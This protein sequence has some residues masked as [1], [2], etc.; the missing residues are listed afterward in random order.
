MRPR[1]LIRCALLFALL[2]GGGLQAEVRA[3]TAELL[4]SEDL[5]DPVRKGSKTTYFHLL[6]KIF[7]DLQEDATAHKTIPLRN[8]LEPAQKVIIQSD[9]TF[10]FKSYWLKSE[11]KRLL[12]LWINLA[13]ETANQATVAS[14]EAVVLAVFRLEPRVQLLDVID[15][16]TDRFT[17]VWED[18][19]RL[20]LNSQSEAFLVYN[21]HWNAG[22][23]YIDLLMLF[24]D[25]GRFKTVTNQFMYNTQ[26]CG[27]TITETPGFRVVADEGNKYPKV[28]VRMKLKKAPDENYCENPS[29]GYTRYYQGVYQWNRAKGKYEGHSRQ[30][31]RFNQF[32]GKRGAAS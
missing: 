19:P 32:N 24:V 10:K 5:P 27:V 29:P 25:A 26:G 31:K 14:G 4:H 28:L 6:R 2:I 15:I 9:I 1:I 3:S 21:H 17:S 23:S 16:K 20:R 18:R 22:E 30:L 11:G 8:I 13:A 7:P 12:M